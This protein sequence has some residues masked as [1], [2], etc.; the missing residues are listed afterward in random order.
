MSIWTIAR[1]ARVRRGGGCYNDPQYARV[2][3][4]GDFDPFDFDFRLGLRLARRCA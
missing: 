3:N 2:A 1:S 4:H